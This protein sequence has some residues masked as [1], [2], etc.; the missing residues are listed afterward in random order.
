MTDSAEANPDPDVQPGTGFD[1]TDLL[2]KVRYGER[3]RY[4]ELNI[5]HSTGSNVPRFDRRNAGIV[6]TSCT[7]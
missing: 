2:Q 1:Q 3:E 7:N 4:V 6:A 5:Q